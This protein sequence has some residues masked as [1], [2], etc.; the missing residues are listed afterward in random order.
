MAYVTLKSSKKAAKSSTKV[1]KGHISKGAPALSSV[2][3]LKRVHSPK[4]ISTAASVSTKY[5]PNRLVS[6]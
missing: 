1:H 6:T 4:A 3:L 5:K 2:P